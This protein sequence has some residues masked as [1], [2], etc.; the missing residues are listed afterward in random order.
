MDSLIYL[1]NGLAIKSKKVYSAKGVVYGKCWGGGYGSYASQDLQ[2]SSLKGLMAEAKKG[3]EKGWLDGGMG[4]DSLKGALLEIEAI[5][6][7]IIKDKAY[8]RSEYTTEFIG[9][10][11]EKEQDFLQ[12]QLYND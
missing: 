1:N 10:L 9:D 12:E 11:T 2:S 7:I 4:F 5:E 8:S 6:T 3:L